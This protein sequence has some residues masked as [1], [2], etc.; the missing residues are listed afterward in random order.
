MIYRSKHLNSC[1]SKEYTKR[2]IIYNLYRGRLLAALLLVCEGILSVLRYFFNYKYYYSYE[3][4]NY[5]NFY[6]RSYGL[7]ALFCAIY[8]I[9]LR[10]LKKFKH[11]PLEKLDKYDF[12]FTLFLTIVL[13]W[14]AMVSLTDQIK[15]THLTSYFIYSTLCSVF[16]SLD[17]THWLIPNFISLSFLF[18]MLPRFQGNINVL[19]SHTLNLSFFTLIIYLTSQ[20]VYKRYFGEYLSRLLLEKS[21][22]QLRLEAVQKNIINKQLSELNEKLLKLSH[23]DELTNIPNRRGFWEH[24]ND[25]LDMYEEGF[26]LTV[27]MCDIDYFKQYNDNY[28]HLQGDEVLKK[29]TNEIYNCRLSEEDFVTR[30]GGEEILFTCCNQSPEKISF[31]ANYIQNRV[32]ALQI[33][34]KYSPCEKIVTVSI[35]AHTMW[36]KNRGDI[37]ECIQKS[38]EAL[39]KAKKMGRNCCVYYEN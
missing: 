39:Y 16:F 29:I 38:D 17:S 12:L 6:I 10:N 2:T 21:N 35:G 11:M 13:I 26:T 8:L 22:T 18:T 19:I 4:Q 7:F 23:I 28:G 37:E 20:V 33:E 15:F 25:L 24:I 32:R 34:H 9:L 31:L 1:E 36:V 27:L 5:L 14:G 30:W 3:G